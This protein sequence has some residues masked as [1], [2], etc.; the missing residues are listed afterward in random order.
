MRWQGRELTRKET[1]S[2]ATDVVVN[3]ILS[4]VSATLNDPQG[5]ASLEIASGL[6]SR[7]FASVTVAP[8]NLT[9][10]A[11]TPSVLASIGRG[12]VRNGE[13]VFA[14]E[15]DSEAVRLLQS[16]SWDVSGGHDPATWIYNLELPGPSGSITKTVPSAGVV[17][18]RYASVPQS[19]WKG[20]GPVSW[21]RRTGELAANLEL[22]MAEEAGGVTGHLLP[23][24]TDGGSGEDDDPLSRLKKDLADL[25][26]RTFLV[27]TTAGG[28]TE[29]RR[30]APKRDWQPMRIGAAFPSANV[31]LRSLVAQSVLSACGCPPGLSDASSDG[32]G[33]RESWRRFLHG[34]LQPVAKIIRGELREKLEIP[35]LSFSFHEL[36]ASDLAGRARAF[37][38]LT[39]SDENLSLDQAAKICGFDLG[40]N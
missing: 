3:S 31:N 32:T 1:R 21:A 7:G 15:V 8:D 40:S 27:E 5:V 19:P 34:T 33:Q 2:D 24:P 17:H 22:R 12:L 4:Y 25:R 28:W 16:S 9:T 38:S 30:A 14:I 36:M 13:V 29:G 37:G 26:G 18:L 11:L 39:G 35:E 20:I 6:W 23:V 10:R